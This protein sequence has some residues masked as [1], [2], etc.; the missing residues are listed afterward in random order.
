MEQANAYSYAVISDFIQVYYIRP[1]YI[2]LLVRVEMSG[3]NCLGVELS[4]VEMSGVD[5]SVG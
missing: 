2:S 3:L 1:C 4:G 5:L